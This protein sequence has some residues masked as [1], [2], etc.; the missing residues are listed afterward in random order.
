[1]GN[2]TLN[3]LSGGK[4]GDFIHALYAIR[5]ICLDKNAKADLYLYDIGWEFGIENTYNELYPILIQEEYINSFNILTDYHLEPIQNPQQNTPI[6]I[7]NLKIK[8]KGYIDLGDYIRSPYLYQKCWSEL[9][10]DTFNFKIPSVYRWL[11]FKSIDT[12]LSETVLV[13]RKHTTRLNS[14]F[15]YDDIL[16]EYEDKLVFISSNIKDYENFPYKDK[17]PFLHITTLEQWL[18]AINSCALFISNLTAP[19][20]LAH[21]LDVPRM[22]ELPYTVDYKHCTGEEKYSDNVYWYLNQEVNNLSLLV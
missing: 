2:K 15:I 5:G 22:I 7:N 11:N 13:H 6:Q 12:T 17:M 21:A 8:D 3:F 1:M 14:D 10:A 19:A 20:A 18:T 9:Y 4:L 16:N